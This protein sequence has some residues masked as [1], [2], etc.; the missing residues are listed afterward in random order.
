[1]YPGGCGGAEH[2]DQIAA[3]PGHLPPSPQNNGIQSKWIPLAR[4]H[5]SNVI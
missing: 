5:V 2:A 3:S 4:P 1:M